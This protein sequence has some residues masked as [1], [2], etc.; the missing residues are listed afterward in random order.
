MRLNTL[1]FPYLLS[2]TLHKGSLTT[3]EEVK[4]TPLPSIMD[5]WLFFNYLLGVT[6]IKVNSEQ[7][8]VHPPQELTLLRRMREGAQKHMNLNGKWNFRAI[9]LLS[10]AT[11]RPHH[12]A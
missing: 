12:Q 1:V 11:E 3:P 7:G 9:V 5:S 10:T 6:L 8:I 2:L 4:Q